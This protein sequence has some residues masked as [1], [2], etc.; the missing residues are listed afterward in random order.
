MQCSYS[1]TPR[2]LEPIQQDSS[3]QTNTTGGT[4]E[5]MLVISLLVSLTLGAFLYKKYRLY[6]TATLQLQVATL[7]RLWKISPKN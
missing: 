2:S 6:R 7:E 4:I 3:L 5:G 1:S